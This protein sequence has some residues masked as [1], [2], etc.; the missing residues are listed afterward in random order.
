MCERHGSFSADAIRL[1]NDK[2]REAEML[3]YM[4]ILGALF[5]IAIFSSTSAFDL[6]LPSDPQQNV[7]SIQKSNPYWPVKGAISVDPCHYRDCTDV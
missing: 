4:R 7:T 1:I 5:I 6:E 3:H 2:N